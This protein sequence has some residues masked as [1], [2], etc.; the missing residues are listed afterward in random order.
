VT[1]WTADE[2]GNE[3]PSGQKILLVDGEEVPLLEV[4]TL[5]F[6]HP[7]SEDPAQEDQTDATADEQ[8]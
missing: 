8:N 2:E 6:D 4:R 5:E 7:D 3:Y 1:D